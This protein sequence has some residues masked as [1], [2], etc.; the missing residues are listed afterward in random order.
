MIHVC[1]AF[2]ERADEESEIYIACIMCLANNIFECSYCHC[3][4]VDYIF[5]ESSRHFHLV[6]IR[7]R[8]NIATLNVFYNPRYVIGI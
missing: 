7:C 4:Y 1:I 5:I 8:R 2:N 3:D 6:C